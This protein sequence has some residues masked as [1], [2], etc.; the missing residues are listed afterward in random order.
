MRGSTECVRTAWLVA[1]KRVSSV[2]AIMNV[3][4]NPRNT[5][6]LEAI[7]GDIVDKVCALDLYVLYS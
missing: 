2:L 5:N 4:S 7:V 3:S 6:D 1:E